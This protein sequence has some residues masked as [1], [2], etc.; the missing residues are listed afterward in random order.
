MSV[1]LRKKVI[2]QRPVFL[3]ARPSLSVS[4]LRKCRITKRS[5]VENVLLQLQDY[6]ASCHYDDHFWSIFL[7]N[8]FEQK[9][10]KASGSSAYV[11][12]WLN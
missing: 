2:G 11:F 12:S 1:V 9:K 6:L 3:I 4:S 10:T 8:T 7:T 5:R